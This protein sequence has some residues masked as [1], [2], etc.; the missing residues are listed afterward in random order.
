VVAAV[1]LW[2]IDRLI[3]ELFIRCSVTSAIFDLK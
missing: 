2:L 3:A 1:A